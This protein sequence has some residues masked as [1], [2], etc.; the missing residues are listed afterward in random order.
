MWERIRHIFL[1]EA[2]QIRRDKRMLMI[3]FVAPIIQIIL[4]G[5][6]ANM[7]VK[8]IPAA[9]LDFSMTQESRELILLFK[10]SGR[11][12]INYFPESQKEMVERLDKGE[13]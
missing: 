2:V 12:Q 1:K 5:Y 7:D 6:A 8:R 13:V 11:F 3:I 4:L 9:V 10:N